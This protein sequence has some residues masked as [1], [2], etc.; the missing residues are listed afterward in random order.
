MLDNG[1]LPD[2]VTFLGVLSACVHAGIVDDGIL[3]FHRM[4]K[5]YGIPAWSEHYALMVDLFGRAGRLHEAFETI[6]S[7]PFSPGSGVWGT[8]LGACRVHGNIELAEEASR[9]LF[10]LEPQNSGYYM[11]LANIYADSGQW[12]NVRKVRNLMTERGVQKIPGY[13]W[14]EVNNK[15]HVFVAADRSHPQSAKL[16]SL[17]NILLLELRKEG[18][19]PQPYLPIFGS[20]AI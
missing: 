20:Q 6:K 5:E 1:I 4:T 3:Y 18:Y 10:D 19:N 8:L 9:H 14:I 2:H 15:T 17:L 7:M 16:H 13:S 12:E 11:L